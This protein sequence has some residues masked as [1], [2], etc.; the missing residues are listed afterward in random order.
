ML[1]GPDRLESIMPWQRHGEPKLREHSNDC[2]DS[3]GELLQTQGPGGRFQQFSSY[4]TLG[5]Y[6]YLNP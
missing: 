1:P 4:V 2:E 5:F 3:I 6:P